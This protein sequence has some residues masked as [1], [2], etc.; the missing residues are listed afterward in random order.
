MFFNI[1]SLLGI[2]FKKKDSIF[3]L[4]GYKIVKY[5]CYENIHLSRRIKYSF[6]RIIKVKIIRLIQVLLARAYKTVFNFMIFLLFVENNTMRYM[7]FQYG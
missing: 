1:I 7:M 6:L 5:D 4:A 2:L 3:I